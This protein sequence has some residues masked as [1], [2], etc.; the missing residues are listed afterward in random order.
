MSAELHFYKDLFLMLDD[1]VQITEAIT[2]AQKTWQKEKAGDAKWD[3]YAD[4]RINELE[5]VLNKIHATRW[6]EL[7]NPN[8]LNK[9]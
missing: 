9:L 3:A 6:K 5:A 1:V 4:K 2:L 8:T 7:P